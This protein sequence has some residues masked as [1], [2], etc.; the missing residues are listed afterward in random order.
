[1]KV[2]VVMGQSGYE[3]I[4]IEAVYSSKK[5]AEVF[6]EKEK[7][8]DPSRWAGTDMWVNTYEVRGIK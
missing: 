5:G 2:Y 8:R 4:W 1:M 6:I 3:D 7:E